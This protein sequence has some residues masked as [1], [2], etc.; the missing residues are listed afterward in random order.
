VRVQGTNAEWTYDKPRQTLYV[1]SS[2][3]GEH[4][5]V[6]SVENEAQHLL[7]RVRRRREL[8]P[9]GFPLSMVSPAMED[10]LEDIDWSMAFAYWPVCAAVLFAVLAWFV[11]VLWMG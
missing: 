2:S 3:P 9:P 4:R 5:V 7:E 1:R 8:Y 6:V 10:F 11:M